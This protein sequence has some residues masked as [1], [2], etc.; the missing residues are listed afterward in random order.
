MPQLPSAP[1]STLRSRLGVAAAGAL[2]AANVVVPLALG[3]LYP[4]TSAPMFRDCPGKCCNYRVFAEDGS[5]LPARN[6][7]LERVYDGNPVGYGVG[8]CPPPVM[9]QEFGRVH[10]EADVHQHLASC[11]ALPQN[12]SHRRIEVVQDVIGPVDGQ[13]VGIVCTHRWQIER[14]KP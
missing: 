13:R 2:L 4:F 6:W 3:D 7:H 11:F 10:A 1:S 9:E 5:E 14:P 12:L 8:I